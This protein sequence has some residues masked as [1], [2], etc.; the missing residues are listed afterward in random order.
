MGLCTSIANFRMLNQRLEELGCV[1]FASLGFSEQG[2]FFDGDPGG[3]GPAVALIPAPILC[4]SSMA[5]DTDEHQDAHERIGRA[6]IE[7]EML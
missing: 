5:V 1:R 3:S 2:A 6:V 7:L 4:T